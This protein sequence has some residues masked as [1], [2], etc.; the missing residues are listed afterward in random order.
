MKFS[1]LS[2][3]FYGVG[4][5]L[6]AY[7]G[8]LVGGVY[9]K[10]MTLNEFVP[11]FQKILKNPFAVYWSRDSPKLIVAFLFI[12]II[13]IFM[14]LSSRVELMAGREHGTAKLANPKQVN[15]LTADKDDRENMII[16]QNVKLSMDN[17]ALKL[18]SNMLVIG[19]SGAGK[20]FHVVTPNVLNLPNASLIFTDPKGELLGN[21]GNVLKQNGYVI[22]VL[23][24]IEMDKSDCFNPFAY[25][26]D[27]TDIIKLINNLIANTTPKGASNTDP[28][29]ESATRSLTV[30]S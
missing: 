28:F 22:R 21:L 3:L 13:G 7:L 12:Y 23:N 4:A 30:T 27:E 16:T 2:V 20:S 26:R 25:I 1:K 29:W 19:G 8:Y 18:N 10:G 11:A 15:K 17:R 5:L 6:S 24:L 9:Q 14:Y